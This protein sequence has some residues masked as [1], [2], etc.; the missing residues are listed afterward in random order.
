M[1]LRKD[2]NRMNKKVPIRG[3]KIH[4][5][6]DGCNS[7]PVIVFLHG[8]TGSTET[9]TEV[10]NALQGKYK[11]VAIDLT[12][13]GLSTVPTDSAR[14]SMEEQIADLKALFK[15]R[16][17]TSFILVG[18]S[19]GGRIALA[20][21]KKHPE[22][23][24]SLILE[25]AS[26][27]IKTKS[28]RIARREADKQLSERIVREGVPSF[29]DFWENIPLFHSQKKL[30]KE[31]QN[32]I[33]QERLKQSKTGLANSLLGIGTGSQPSYWDD[34]NSIN[35]PVLLITGEIDMKFVNIAQEMKE[36]LPLANHRTVKDVGHAIHV[37]N[38][39]LFATMIMEHVAKVITIRR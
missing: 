15:Q 16:K 13:H 7:L 21:T 33:R 25:S 14:Y 28:E 24:T 23:V 32:V 35:V 31:K 1:K 34:L 18:Y 2:L 29:V 8:F 38:P 36:Y 3:Q 11:T 17:L 22:Q 39:T 27:G 4:V 20:Y 12:G 5:T 6:S 37:E 19:M 30:P 10:I 9:W 26:P